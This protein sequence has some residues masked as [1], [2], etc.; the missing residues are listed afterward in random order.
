MLIYSESKDRWPNSH[1][2]RNHSFGSGLSF[3][4]SHHPSLHLQTAKSKK[5]SNS[6]CERWRCKPDLWRLLRPRSKDGGGGHQCLLLLWLWGWKKQGNRQQ[7]LRWILNLVT[8]ICDWIYQFTLRIVWK[9]SRWPGNF[10]KNALVLQKWDTNFLLIWHKNDLIFVQSFNIQS[11]RI[12][13]FK[14]QFFNKGRFAK[15]IFWYNF[16]S[17]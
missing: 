8:Q 6:R 15:L 1:N 3:S 10:L 13:S 5:E 16:K 2:R 4:S 12:K 14:I 11:F 17:F 7:S 9:L